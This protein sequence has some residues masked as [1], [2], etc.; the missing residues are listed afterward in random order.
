MVVPYKLFLQMD[1]PLLFIAGSAL[2]TWS[3]EAPNSSSPPHNVMSGCGCYGETFTTGTSQSSQVW[4]A[5]H[6]SR[7][8]KSPP[9]PFLYFS[10]NQM[11]FHT[12]WQHTLGLSPWLGWYWIPTYCPSSLKHP[13]NATVCPLGQED[14]DSKK[15]APWKRGRMIVLPPWFFH[16]WK[17]VTKKLL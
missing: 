2:G 14:S 17:L 12:N 4:F 11:K 6:H 16:Q 9:L 15:E 13:N 10:L 3:L 8:K 7:C 1:W 5:P